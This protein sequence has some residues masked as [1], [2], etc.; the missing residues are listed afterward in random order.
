MPKFKIIDPTFDA[1]SWFTFLAPVGRR[2]VTSSLKTC[3]KRCTFK[4]KALHKSDVYAVSL[5]KFQIFRENGQ[6][7]KCLNPKLIVYLK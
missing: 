5:A 4:C 3:S 7:G 1:G 2:G 6:G